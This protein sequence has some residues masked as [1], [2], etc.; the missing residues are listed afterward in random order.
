M[1]KASRRLL[2]NCSGCFSKLDLK[3]RM[4]KDQDGSVGKVLAL[5]ARRDE[6]EPQCLRALA[7]LTEELCSVSQAPR[8]STQASGA[9]DVEGANPLFWPL[10]APGTHVVH[11]YLK[12]KQSYT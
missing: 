5:Q 8:G 10:A 3:E 1:R 11:T 2:Y 6:F 7:A 4:F 12:T 9:P